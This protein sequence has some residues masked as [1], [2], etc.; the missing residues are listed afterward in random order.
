MWVQDPQKR[1]DWR[2]V[3]VIKEVGMGRILET[4][5]YV[6][7]PMTH[8]KMLTRGSRGTRISTNLG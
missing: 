6:M 1:R 4:N 8:L 2:K 3:K 5:N 7:W